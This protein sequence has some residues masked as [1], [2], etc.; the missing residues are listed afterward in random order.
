MSQRHL[1]TS[2]SVTE[3]H[4]DK[5]A[6][7][8]SDGVLDALLTQDSKSRVACETMVTTG[9]AIVAGEITTE[10]YVEISDIVRETLKRI[11]YDNAAYGIDWETCAVMT[12]IDRQSPDIAMG[13]NTGGAGDQG[14]MFGYATDES[15]DLMPLP[16]S[17]AHKVC[18]KLAAV[19]KSGEVPFL[20]P[21]GKS[22]VTVEYD[23]DRPVRIDTVVLSTQH[24]EEATQKQIQE[25][26]IES[27][28]K[29]VLPAELIDS[30][31]PV[32]YHV[33]PTGRFVIG[34][35]HG[36]CGLT[37]RKIIVDT[38][39]G[40]G[41]HGGGA[42]SGKDPSKVDRSACYA[43]RHVAK[44]LVAAGV[45]RRL[46]VQ[47][48]Y[49]IGVA[50]PVSIHVDTFGTGRM[51]GS[52]I[53]TL[54]REHFD[55]TPGGIIK[56]LDLLRPMYSRTAAYGH[57]GREDEGFPWEKRDKVDALKSLVG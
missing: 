38:Y 39:G 54:I 19:R 13:V 43:A 30:S 51:E 3:G 23:G 8:I 33:N 37:G 10:A 15:P 35:P 7:Q 5:V 46:E 1:F 50:E 31:R 34:G 29:P 42:F 45:A 57:F 55:L 47:V 48:A 41:R 14:L 2:E 18:S 53:V 24:H 12:S 11:G 28:I 20:R 26:M 25:A 36:D 52:E 17:L 32:K 9:V 16:I 56:A 21:D 40:M 22:Q 44:N 27:V 4:P 49:A 6:D